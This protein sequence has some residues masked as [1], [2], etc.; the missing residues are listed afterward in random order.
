MSWA[1][2]LDER[3][4][5]GAAIAVEIGSGWEAAPCPPGAHD[6]P[7]GIDSLE[8]TPARV[9]GTA[10]GALRAAGR[11]DPAEPADLDAEDWWFRA[12]F[13]AA[14]AAAGEEAVLCLEGIATVAD[15]H[16]NGEPVLRSE[17]MFHAHRV[18]V[19]E[20]LR[21]GGNEL[22]IRCHALGPLL[23]APRRP[24][25]RWRTQ[26]AAG[27]LRFQ[28]TMLLGR[29]PGVA[30]APAAVGPWRPV[31]LERRRLLAAG[32]IRRRA[33][34][35]GDDGVLELSVALR[36]LG[37]A[38]PERGTVVLRGPSGERRAALELAEA[39]GELTAI[40]SLRIPGVARWW[41]HTHG[42][43]ALHEVSVLLEVG[44]EEVALD[45]G[46]VGFR[47]LAPGPGAGHDVEAEG[48]DLHV[49]GVR[50]FA[51]GAVWTPLDPIGLAPAREEMRAALEEARDAGMN[52]VRLPGTGAYEEAAFHDLCDELGILVWQDFMFANFDYPVADAGFRASVEREARE[53]LAGLAGR[54]S[55]AVLCGNSEVE[56]QVAMLGLDPAPG[57]G[58]LFGELLP[59]LAEESGADAAYVPS[60]PCGGELPFRT[61]AGVAN[62]YGVGGY[63]RP[64]TDARL[65][66]VRFAG[67]CLAISNVPDDPPASVG[68]PAWKDGVPRD[69]GAE[70]D[71]E[72]VRDH[73]LE[74]LYGLDPDAL[75][76]ADPE[77]YLELSRA[78]SGELMAAVF[79]EWRRAASPCGGGLVLWMRDFSPG[80]GWGVMDGNGKPKVALRH[81]ARALAPRAVWLTDE[82]LGGIDAHV[83]NDRAEPLAARLRVALYRELEHPVAEA[84]E[85]VEL[86]PHETRRFGVEAMIGRFAD[87]SWAYRF[88]P[89]GQDL[90]V[91]ALERGSG[92]GAETISRAFH[93][94]VGRP[95][96]P[97]PAA[98]LGLE[99][100]ARGVAGGALALELRTRR[101]VHGL[102]VSAAG[103]VAEDDAFSL[104]PGASRSLHIR[105]HPGGEPE[106]VPT[107]TVRALNLDGAIEVAAAE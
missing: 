86:A 79:G 67:E 59:A 19:G 101:L 93:F 58:E 57:R 10:A 82:G 84:V 14:P 2:L 56:Q 78:V 22:A 15:V 18:D 60:S 8:W 68:D 49:N 39:G 38:R 66:R 33:R 85:E 102:R 61:D 12:R 41:P 3:E 25:A 104:E 83:A 30:A 11:W 81:L 46:R 26:L 99:L 24:R 50:V 107:I 72:D 32:P 6:G 94:P 74:D 89:P 31:R 28:R 71:F 5:D 92:A 62:Y 42:E 103:Y 4:L 27:G 69:S 95:S 16:L 80:A 90:V 23:A 7:G 73:Y 13:E 44:G 65:A 75:R 52:M 34:L 98:D 55:L 48:L 87:V 35:D 51:R 100:G 54:P 106:G 88:G 47:A 76:A 29:M 9:P 53:A 36:P 37:G 105:P 77:R 43:P 63:R 45:G 64:L 91:A 1:A 21:E 17:S 20:R 97:E 96:M 70:W 40:G